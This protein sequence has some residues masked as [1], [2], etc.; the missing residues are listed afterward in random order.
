MSLTPPAAAAEQRAEHASDQ[1]AARL[2]SDRTRCALCQRFDETFTQTA[3]C[4]A[5]ST[6][7][8]A[9]TTLAVRAPNGEWLCNDDSNG[10]NPMV[11]W[12]HPRSGRYQIWVGTFGEPGEEP[13]TPSRRGRGRS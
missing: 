8:D 10:L 11:S 2:R 12:E 7:S 9:D 3:Q 4:V 13:V 6:T 5:I 1:R